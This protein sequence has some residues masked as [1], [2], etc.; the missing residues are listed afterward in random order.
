MVV[1]LHGEPMAPASFK[2]EITTTFPCHTKGASVDEVTTHIDGCISRVSCP[3]RGGRQESQSPGFASLKL[4]SVLQSGD[5]DKLRSSS[6]QTRL[7]PFLRKGIWEE[8]REVAG[9]AV[10]LKG[11]H[12]PPQDSQCSL[13]AHCTEARG[14]QRGLEG[15]CPSRLPALTHRP[16]PQYPLP[17][18]PVGWLTLSQESLNR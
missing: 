15:E 16:C 9:A 2:V 17:N 3:A 13:P 18:L 12:S 6:E 11:C 5:R 8:R 10:E 7:S 4:T 14:V 1:F